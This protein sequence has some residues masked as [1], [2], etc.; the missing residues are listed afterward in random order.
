MRSSFFSSVAD[1]LRSRVV[2]S[3]DGKEGIESLE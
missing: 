3:S 2:V 1:G